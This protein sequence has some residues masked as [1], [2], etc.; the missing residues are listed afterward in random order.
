[1]RTF[2]TIALIFVVIFGVMGCEE[3]SP[4][5]NNKE[6]V[7]IETSI[8]GT[9]YLNVEHGFRLS[10]LPI[11]NWVIEMRQYR[12]G[13]IEDVLLMAFTTEDKFVLDTNQLEDGLIPYAEVSVYGPDPD[14]PS[15]PDVAKEV[16]NIW[17]SAWEQIGITVISRNPVAGINTTGYEAILFLP[18]TETVGLVK[19]AFFA[20]H[21]KGYIISLWAPEDKYSD[22]V[23]YIDSIIANFEL[24]GL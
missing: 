24:V 18:G 19:W 20:K 11:S 23:V 3:E 10:N 15:K 9:D 21:D 16:M 5:D 8:S 12:E 17:I 14:L 7:K 22:S 1:M 13:I 6:P 2:I 4:T